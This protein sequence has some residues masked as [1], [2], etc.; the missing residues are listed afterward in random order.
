MPSTGPTNILG[1][2]RERARRGAGKGEKGR[3]G[4]GRERKEAR[5]EG[6]RGKGGE[7]FTVLEPS[8]VLL[9]TPD[10]LPPPQ[11]QVV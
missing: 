2:K 4:I 5:R 10:M 6:Q 1:R 7:E 9:H 8:C 11:M 3:R